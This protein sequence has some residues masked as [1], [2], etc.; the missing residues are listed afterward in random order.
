MEHPL[1]R[2]IDE[3]EDLLFIRRFLNRSDRENTNKASLIKGNLL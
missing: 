1:F 3:M 2:I